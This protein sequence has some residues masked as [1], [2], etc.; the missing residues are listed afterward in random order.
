MVRP[1]PL[2]QTRLQ[3]KTYGPRFKQQ[4]RAYVCSNGQPAQPAKMATYWRRYGNGHTFNLRLPRSFDVW[5]KNVPGHFYTVLCPLNNEIIFGDL[6]PPKWNS[7]QRGVKITKL[8]KPCYAFSKINFLDW[9]LGRTGVGT[10]TVQIS[11]C[12]LKRW[13]INKNFI[14]L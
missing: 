10:Q 12:F 11:E 14:F 3:K 8:G 1:R 5:V 4:L 2:L 9:P 7:P 6:R 13:L